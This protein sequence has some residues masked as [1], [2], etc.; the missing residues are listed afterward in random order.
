MTKT[1]KNLNNPKT[2]T[3]LYSRAIPIRL[4]F[5]QKLNALKPSSCMVTYPSLGDNIYIYSMI[6]N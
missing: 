2:F 3:K 5:V 4:S 6:E 1:I